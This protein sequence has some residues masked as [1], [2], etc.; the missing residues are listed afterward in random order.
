MKAS[1]A[2]IVNYLSHSIESLYTAQECRRIARMVAAAL[3]KE[4]ESKFLTDPTEIITIDNI[5]QI[6]YDLGAGRP[7]QYII[8]E[9]DF[10]S[11]PF[12]VREGVLIPRPETEEL[13]MWA[14]QEAKAFASP[15]IL[16]LCT[17]SGCIAIALKKLIPS[18]TVT[19]VD[20][21]C[22]ALTIA[23]EN[24]TKLN[25]P[26]RLLQDDVLQGVEKLQ[27]EEFDLI[28]SNP[29]YIPLSERAN[30]HINVTEHE[31][32]LALFVEDND[33]LIFYREIARFAS[34]SLAPQGRLMFEIHELLADKTIQMLH[35]EGFQ[36]ALHHDFLSKPR[37]L[38]CQRNK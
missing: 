28:I 19:A 12:N 3:S 9:C 34:R 14:V 23:R 18:A 11:M 38:C 13:V 29:P 36:A 37:M 4:P 27:G 7:V 24:A 31:P 32:S 25:A 21:S 26:I 2:E 16:D 35:H 10:C 8:G 20:I 17:G 30:M 1:R 33:P 5:E 22:E 15:R 6:A